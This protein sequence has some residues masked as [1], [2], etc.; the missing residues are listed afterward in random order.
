MTTPE[1]VKETMHRWTSRQ[2]ILS[3]VGMGL[4]FA[5]T[6]FEKDVGA[7]SGVVIVAIG[8]AAGV[9]FKERGVGGGSSP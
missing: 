4:M 7:L 5:A 1:R 8:G 6:M 3:L 9:N 2:F